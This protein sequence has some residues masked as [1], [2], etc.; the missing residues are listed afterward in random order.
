MRF[1]HNILRRILSIVANVADSDIYITAFLTCLGK[2]YYIFKSW[3]ISFSRPFRKATSW[4]NSTLLEF[5]WQVSSCHFVVQHQR[6]T[7]Y[8]SHGMVV[9]GLCYPSP[10]TFP[11]SCLPLTQS[12]ASS[13]CNKQKCIVIHSQSLQLFG[14]NF[15][16]ALRSGFFLLVWSRQGIILMLFSWHGKSHSNFHTRFFFVVSMFSN[17]AV[18]QFYIYPPWYLMQYDWLVPSMRLQVIQDSLFS[19]LGSG[20]FSGRGKRESRNRTSFTWAINGFKERVA[21]KTALSQSVPFTS[22]E[23]HWDGK[24]WRMLLFVKPPICKMYVQMRSAV[25]PVRVAIRYMDRPL[26]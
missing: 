19:R 11:E 10:S 16:T 12:S 3:S 6:Q 8:V 1:F 24:R 21:E 18:S 25:S 22:N 17:F 7:T 9:L 5:C 15:P 13:S 2:L 4:K 23:F 14:N 26:I 20:P